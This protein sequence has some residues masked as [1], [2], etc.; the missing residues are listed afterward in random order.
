ILCDC[1]NIQDCILAITWVKYLEIGYVL[2]INIEYGSCILHL[3]TS[4]LALKER[5]TL[6][7]GEAP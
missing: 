3:S 5:Y 4:F 6:A 7:W 1:S 2:R